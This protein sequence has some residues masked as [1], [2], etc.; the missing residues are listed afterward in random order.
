[1]KFPSAQNDALKNGTAGLHSL[2]GD[3]VDAGAVVAKGTGG[4]DPLPSSGCLSP[5][6]TTSPSPPS[7]PDAGVVCTSAPLTNAA[8][9]VRVLV[10]VIRKPLNPTRTSVC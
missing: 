6:A 4:N 7:S 10:R 2:A 5:D 3:S 9:D 1:M 8:K